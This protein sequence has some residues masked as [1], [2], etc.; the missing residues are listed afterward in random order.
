ME[1]RHSFLQDGNG[2]NINRK[3]ISTHQESIELL[4]STD[5]EMIPAGKACLARCGKLLATGGSTGLLLAGATDVCLLRTSSISSG[6]GVWC[7]STLCS[8]LQDG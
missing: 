8:C 6:V 4:Q 3:D 7:A 2:V 1:I 5:H